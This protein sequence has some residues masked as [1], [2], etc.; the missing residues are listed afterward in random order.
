MLERYEDWAVADPDG[1]DLDTV[2]AICDDIAAR[3]EQLLSE[4]LPDL[5]TRPATSVAG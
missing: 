4:V 3:V 5:P 1:A 2:R